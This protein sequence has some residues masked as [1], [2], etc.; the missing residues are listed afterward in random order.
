MP[1]TSSPGE[2]GATNLL[3][4]GD[5]RGHRH[6][7]LFAGLN[8]EPKGSTYHDPMTGAQI[9]SGASADI[10]V[11]GPANDFREFTTFFQDGLNLRDNNGAVIEDPLDHPPTPEEP[12]GSST[13]AE[14]Q[15]EKG[16]IS[17]SEP[18]RNRI[19]IGPQTGADLAHVFSSTLHGD[20]PPPSSG[21][22]PATQSGCGC[23]RVQTS[24]ARTPSSSTVA[25][26]RPSRPIRCLPSSAPRAPSASAAQRT[27]T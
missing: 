4:F 17:G 16:F 8:V 25:I 24:P 14:D 1:T 6:H 3:D 13:D 19:G 9:T 27:F 22:T 15:G 21:P 20:R 2:I 26:G 7:G 10:H 5:V 18:F 11:P 12:L 23:R